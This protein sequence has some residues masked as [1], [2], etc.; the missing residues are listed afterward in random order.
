MLR[1]VFIHWGKLVRFGEN[2]GQN[3]GLLSCSVLPWEHWIALNGLQTVVIVSHWHRYRGLYSDRILLLVRVLVLLKLRS[4]NIEVRGCSWLILLDPILEGREE[5][6]RVASSP[7]GQQHLL[8]LDR[9]DKFVISDAWLSLH[10]H[11]VV[12]LSEVK[13]RLLLPQFLINLII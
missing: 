4:G 2:P 3:V 1:F 7:R 10:L 8:E 11:H 6:K 5:T 13:I 12:I 9:L